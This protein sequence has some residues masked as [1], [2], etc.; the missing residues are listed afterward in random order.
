MKRV[1]LVALAFVITACKTVTVTNPTTAKVYTTPPEITLSFPKGKPDK[2]SVFVNNFDVTTR[3]TVTD[4]GATLPSDAVLPLLQENENF[5]IVKV[6]A[7]TPRVKFIYDTTG[8]VV[9]VTTTNVG[10][11]VQINGFVEDASGVKSVVLDGVAVPLDASNNFSVTTSKRAFYAFSTEDNNG[12]K[13]DQKFADPSVTTNNSISVRIN[14]NGLNFVVGQT[15]KIL[16][17]P[18]LGQMVTKFNP[19]K[20][21]KFILDTYRIDVNDARIGRAELALS[22]TATSGTFNVSGT[23]Y[24][25]WAN[26]KF[27]YDFWAPLLPTLSKSGNIMLDSA[28]FSGT[29][30]VSIVNGSVK[31]TIPSLNVGLNTLRTDI[32]GFP[33]GFASIFYD[34]FN[35][36]FEI[37][38]ADQIKQIL[39]PKLAEFV[40]TFPQ[41]LIVDI[42]GS[43]L[44]PDVKPQSFSSSASMIDLKLSSRVYNLTNNGPKLLGSDWKDVPAVPTA[45]NVSP[46]GKIMD[47]GAMISQDMVNQVLSAATASGLLSLNLSEKDV[48]GAAGGQIA[49]IKLITRPVQAPVI[50]FVKTSRGIAKFRMHDFY[51]RLDGIVDST[52]TYKTLMGAVVDIEAFVNIG[53]DDNGMLGLEFVNL[54]QIRIKKIE[55]GTLTLSQDLAQAFMDETVRLTLPFIQRVTGRIPL[56]SF[57]GLK[58]NIGEMWVPQTGVVGTNITIVDGTAVKDAAP[59]TMMTANPT[60]DKNLP[61]VIMLSSTATNAQYKYKLD[62]NPW[63][64]WM[65]RGSV[66]LYGLNTGDHTITVCSRTM[67]LIEDKVCTTGTFTVK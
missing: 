67:T 55:Q 49:N 39:P 27:S 14:K 53:V 50:D 33:D 57:E 30:T 36:L 2:L 41:T 29:A 5:V 9:H 25:V 37:I 45:S 11:N 17:S 32:S 43:Q 31:V 3:L 64:F 56:P 35:W 65:A 63:S 15:A 46:A 28:T 66:D 62:N 18:A 51:V 61:V 22:G 12:F 4:A 1:I 20:E 19:I 16:A 54:P 34:A 6:P 58:I 40:D 59:A 38:L 42:N 26:G 44:K 23:F 47:V 21:D 13:R 24:D 7:A 10:T 8:P 52:M 48:L 60:Y